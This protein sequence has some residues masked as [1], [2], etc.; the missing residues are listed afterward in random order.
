MRVPGPSFESGSIVLITD[1]CHP[2]ASARQA[3]GTRIL[4]CAGRGMEVRVP[5]GISPADVSPVVHFSPNS[6]L[7]VGGRSGDRSD[8]DDP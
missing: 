6:T 3:P 5:N 8:R 4:L 2:P 7:D 1:A